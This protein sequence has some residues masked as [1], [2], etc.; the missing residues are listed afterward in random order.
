LDFKNDNACEHE[1]GNENENYE[2]DYEF[3]NGNLQ[4]Y[5]FT[6]EDLREGNYCVCQSLF[7]EGDYMH[8]EI[9]KFYEEN[10]KRGVYSSKGR[11]EKR[12]F[13][14]YRGKENEE[15]EEEAR[16]ITEFEETLEECIFFKC[17]KEECIIESQLEI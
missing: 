12:G 5:E 3:V 10:L 7:F 17:I 9:Y 4:D 11:G 2:F 13:A 8:E 1:N 14:S 6:Y 15:G 16:V